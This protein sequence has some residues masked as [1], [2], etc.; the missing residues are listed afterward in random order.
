PHIYSVPVP[1]RRSCD[2]YARWCHLPTAESAWIRRPSSEMPPCEIRGMKL[3]LI[4]SPLKVAADASLANVGL[5]GPNTVVDTSG[6]TCCPDRK[7]T[8]LNFSHVKNS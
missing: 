7:S 3:M 1:P 8:R 2:L 5:V 6:A 4:E